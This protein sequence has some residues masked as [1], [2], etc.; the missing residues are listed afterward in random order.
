MC[1]I[2]VGKCHLMYSFW[3]FICFHHYPPD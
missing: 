3:C 2:A 1:I